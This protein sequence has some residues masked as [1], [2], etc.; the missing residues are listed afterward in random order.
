MLTLE[1][2]DG[3]EVVAAQQALAA[4]LGELVVRVDEPRP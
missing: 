4:R 2:R 1:G 3:A